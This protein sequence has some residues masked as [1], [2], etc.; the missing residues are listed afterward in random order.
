MYIETTQ[1]FYFMRTDCKYMY[2]LYIFEAPKRL[3][4]KYIIYDER[5][6]LERTN[7][8]QQMEN[9]NIFYGEKSILDIYLLIPIYFVNLFKFEFRL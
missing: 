9:Q 5:Y 6:Y 1:L 3:Q 8:N 4:G 2:I 7:N